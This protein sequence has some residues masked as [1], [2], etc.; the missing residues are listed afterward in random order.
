[1][2]IPKGWHFFGPVSVILIGFVIHE[3]FNGAW[4]VIVFVNIPLAPIAWE[5]A[6]YIQRTG[7]AYQMYL[8]R[9]GGA[10][11]IEKELI[12][13]INKDNKPGVFV[14]LVRS[15]Q[16]AFTQVVEMPAFNAEQIF[17]KDVLG[18]YDMDPVTQEHV[19]LTEEKWVIQ[20][21]RFSQ[22]PFANMKKKWEDFGLLERA[23][24]NK[25]AKFIVKS[26]LAVELVASGKPLP[27]RDTPPL[28]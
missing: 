16:P 4:E 6:K 27:A 22:K 11:P 13:E 18:M 17:A 24:A 14:P 28:K 26:R 10:A 3:H 2:N 9:T 15:I 12:N 1:M 20:K 8:T 5:W 23:N 7:V 19:D 25:N 21:K